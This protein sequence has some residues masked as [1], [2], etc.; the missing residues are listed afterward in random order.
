MRTSMSMN[1]THTNS[2][3]V[4]GRKASGRTYAGL[5]SEATGFAAV[6]CQGLLP[7]Y[8]PG[9]ILVRKDANS[10]INL[11]NYDRQVSLI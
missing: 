11:R 6:P 2:I 7:A 5:F 10:M 8:L 1:L 9:G 3:V 4:A